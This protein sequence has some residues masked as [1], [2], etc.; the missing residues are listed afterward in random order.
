MDIRPVESSA[1]TAWPAWLDLY[2]DAWPAQLTVV[3]LIVAGGAAMILGRLEG[4]FPFLLLV[5]ANRDRFLARMADRFRRRP[6]LVIALPLAGWTLPLL[7]NPPMPL[8]D[9]LR[10]VAQ[11]AWPGGYAAMYVGSSLPPGELYPTFDA[12]A[13]ALGRGLGPTAAVHVLQG[14]LVAAFVGVFTAA[15]HRLVPP[16]EDRAY[17]IAAAVIAALSVVGVRLVLG[18]PEMF[19]SVW[20]IAA[21]LPAGPA[22]IAAWVASGLLLSTGYWLAPVYFVSALLL[23]LRLGAR[24]LVLAGMGAAWLAAWPAL[25]GATP[26]EQLAWLRLVLA[27]RL[28]GI[29]VGENAP[30]V[31]LAALPVFVAVSGL[32]AACVL[33]RRGDRRLVLLALWFCL[34]NQ[35]RYVGIVAPL[36]LL[37][38]LGSIGTLRLRWPPALRVGAVC[39]GLFVAAHSVDDL[40]R[41]D[42]LPRFE[43]P[44]DAVVLTAFSEATYGVPFFNPGRVKVAP[45]FEVGAAE[46]WLQQV[47]ADVAGGL[48][49]CEAIA[50]RG[51]THV[52]ERTLGGSAPA[53]VEIVAT[54]GPW[55]LWRV[56]P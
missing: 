35:A 11:G 27:Q 9:L 55:R 34:P 22:G 41:I 29:E 20:A 18:R 12:L 21:L 36:L 10:H 13:G 28:P 39:L 56:R 47:V 43:L 4:V 17:W 5:V 6:W 15:A 24:L 30:M 14:A 53:C 7:G 16:G 3:A 40:P 33:G 19:L 32:T 51:F 37:Y 46:P 50:V 31:M 26:W 38:L 1:R 54:Q 25:A 44:A 48:L 52:V 2:S 8:D 23:P 45:A 42:K 49:P